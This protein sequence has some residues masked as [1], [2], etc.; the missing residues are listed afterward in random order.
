MP[1]YDEPNLLSNMEDK[2]QEAARILAG[3][4]HIVAFTGAGMSVE[5]G[6][7]PFRGEGGIWNQ[8][9]P[10]AL[11]IEYY[12]RHTQESW[13]IIRKVFY[14]YFNN[15]EVQPNPGHRVLAKWEK[16]GRLDCVIT[17]NID[18]LHTVAGN[19]NVLEFHGNMSRF[20]CS[21]CGVKFPAKS[22]KF[23]ETPPLCEQCGGLLKPDF[24]FFGEG[25]PQE[26]YYGSIDA[27]EKCDTF[28]IIGTSGQV[29]PANMIPGIAKNHGAKIIEINRE[30]S[31]YTKHISDLYLEGKSGEILPKIDELMGQ[32]NLA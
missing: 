9:D 22:I 15:S 8:Y 3:S 28:V 25:I 24:I 11:E 19:R 31:T 27:A 7:P 14:D 17:Q 21:K 30:P 32:A 13:N 20:L 5:S 18:D 29:S 2:I 16:E 1:H 26:A 12:Y 10:D 23:T 4:K 6:I